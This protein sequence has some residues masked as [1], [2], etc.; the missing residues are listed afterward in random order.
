MLLLILN[1][2]FPFGFKEVEGIHSRTNFDLGNH[3]SFS[4]KKLRYYD[5]ETGE[6]YIPYVVETSI[7]SRQNVPPGN[8]GF[9]F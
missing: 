6:S 2:R 4:G 8:L 5:P 1:N 7:W 9:F 3:E